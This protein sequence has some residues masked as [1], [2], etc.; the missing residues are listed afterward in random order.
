M[1]VRLL[2]DGELRLLRAAGGEEVVIARTTHRGACS[3]AVRAHVREAVPDHE[4]TVLAVRASRF[5]RLRAADSR[6]SVREQSPMAA[7]LLDGLCTGVRDSEATLR[8][9]EHL[10]QL[11]ALSA[12]PAHDLKDPAAAAVRA[13]AQLRERVAGTRHEL[14][15]LATGGTDPE[16]IGQLVELVEQ[17]V[18]R[19]AETLGP[20]GALEESDLEEELADH[21]QGLGVAGAHDLAP[22]FAAAG[23]DV[24]RVDEIAGQVGG[25]HRD[26][27]FRWLAHALETEALVEEVE[28]ASTRTSTLVGAVEQYSHVDA[29]AH[30]DVDLHPGLDSTAVVLGHEQGGG[31]TVRREHDR[32]L[33]PVPGHA[34]ELNT[35]S[36][37]R[38]PLV[39]SP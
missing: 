29:A 15:L 38:L 17:V 20:L 24:G 33:P 8:Q 23:R 34:G 16:A 35:T 14:G 6:T 5:L 36:T 39:V 31:A 21:L 3:G 32:E 25:P 27:A 37:A 10:A 18:E 7:R 12:N 28:D 26:G 22:V 9:R 11:G 30:A 1:A 13:T 2:V 4:T 19:A